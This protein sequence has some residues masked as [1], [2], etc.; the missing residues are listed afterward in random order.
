[1]AFV[2]LALGILGA[3]VSAIGSIAGGEA[4]ANAANY[5]AEVAQNNATIAKQNAAY[6]IAAGQADVEKEGLKNAAAAGELK[7][8][9]AANGVDVNTGSAVDVQVG[10]R[11]QGD[12]DAQT[13]LNNA[14][15]KAYGYESQATGFTA[16]AGLDKQEA[17]DAPIGAG[18][19]AAGGLLGSASS[20]GFKW[21][22]SG[23]GGSTFPTVAQDQP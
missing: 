16:Q 6:S 17:E 21:T 7:A 10:Q 13:T 8:S 5:N 19:S 11:E 4:T 3:G 9:Q 12:L 2:P 22:G 14:E 20:L 23:G 1:M 15:L 18:L